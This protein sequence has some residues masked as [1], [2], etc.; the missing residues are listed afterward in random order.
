GIAP[1]CRGLIVPLFRDGIA[2][3]LAPCSQL[4]LA[5][6]ILLASQNG[7]HVINISGGQFAPSG[8]AHPVLA[9]AIRYSADKGILMVAAAGNQGC[10]C[11]HVPAALP[12]VLA[13]GA[14]TTEGVPLDYSNW[15]EKYQTQGILAPGENIL[16][17]RPGGEIAVSSGTSYAAAIV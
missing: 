11:L 3:G 7:A 4:D 1:N 17:A 6:A 12:S 10:E 5:R 2:S 9:D 16:G 8:A 13:V 15:G 14:M